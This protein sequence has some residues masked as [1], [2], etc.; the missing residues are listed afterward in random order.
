[1]IGHWWLYGRKWPSPLS[2]KRKLGHPN[3]EGPQ[4]IW[5]LPSPCLQDTHTQNFVPHKKTF[6][7]WGE[8]IPWKIRI[9]T[10]YQKFVRVGDQ[11]WEIV[12]ITI[13]IN[14]FCLRFVFAI[15]YTGSFQ[16]LPD[17]NH[18]YLKCQFPPK[19]P[20]WPKSLVYKPSEKQLSPF[21]KLEL[22]NVHDLH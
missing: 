10:D 8:Y 2:P 18:P 14:F 21:L 15:F 20:I 6:V 4:E 16:V 1:M 13:R 3:T 7:G 17:K 9:Q 12:E 19:I 5:N 11:K 22:E